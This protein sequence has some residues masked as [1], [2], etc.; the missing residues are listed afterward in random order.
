MDRLPPHNIEA[1]EALLG[2][3]LLDG[4]M[5][6]RITVKADDFYSE[7]NRFIFE[8]CRELKQK[9]VSLNQITVAG[10]LSNKE[11][12]ENCGGAAFLSHLTTCT[13]TSLDCPYYAEI[14]QKLS[15]KRKLIALSD[16]IAGLGYKT[17]SELDKDLIM[18]DDL[19][20][21]LRKQTTNIGI[22]TPEMRA[23]MALDNYSRLKDKS[24]GVAVPTGL[25]DVDRW[26]GGGGYPGD[27]ILI[28]GRAGIGKT[29]VAKTI[30]N[31]IGASGK[32]V[33]YFTCEMKT[34]SLTDRDVAGYLGVP[35][36][37]VRYGDY[38]SV[39]SS[40]YV[41]IV[42]KAIPEIVQNQVYHVDGLINTERIRQTS[43][44][45]K[46][47]YGLSAIMV[48]YLG[49]LTDTYG[50]TD[51]QRISYISRTLKQIA[52]ELDVP[53]FSPVQLNRNL[54]SREDKRPQLYDLKDS[55]SLEQDADVVLLIYR[56][57]Y[58]KDIDDST[59]EVIIAKKRQGSANKSVKV[60]FDEKH[61]K[62][63]NLQRSYTNANSMSF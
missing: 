19:L 55:G 45:M 16:Q 54:E 29:T 38:D 51:V 6:D 23:Q 26:L 52:I 4:A 61:Q 21:N 24:G 33:L 28:G 32:N 39:D 62:Y 30:A 35:V 12:L 9:G 37:V 40:L 34:Q 7:R 49:L 57:N 59:A 44:Q 14:I 17:D 20:M 11:L 46:H 25:I 36:D 1:E 63:C 27:Y 43:L 13:P 48:D 50:K 5:L 15:M 53:L 41:D 42:S 18:V 60:Y 10:E 56:E 22:V 58:Y 47:R 8:A 31:N 3:L 2:S